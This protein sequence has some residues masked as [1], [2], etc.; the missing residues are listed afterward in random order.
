MTFQKGKSGN[1]A[2]R[3]RKADK[4][5]KPIAAAE[6]QIAAWLPEL[7]QKQMELA[8]EG[9][10]AAIEYLI[11]RLMGKPTERQEHDVE[12]GSYVMDLSETDDSG[13]TPE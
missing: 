4:F 3:P 7:I 2:G 6:K 11:N 5:A 9:D 1:P 10:R 13:T 12:F 8:R